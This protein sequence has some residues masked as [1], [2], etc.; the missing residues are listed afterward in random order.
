MAN[1]KDELPSAI[2]LSSG[3]TG[4]ATIRSLARGGMT[5]YAATSGSSQATDL[6]RHCRPLRRP[7]RLGDDASSTQWLIDFCGSLPV[8]PVVL[9]TSDNDALWLARHAQALRPHCIFS[10]S[11]H[12]ELL[13]IIS[14]DGL[15]AAGEQTGV[16]IVPSITEPSLEALDAWSLAH[17]APYLIKPFYNC[18]PGS[19]LK[20]KNLLVH[21]RDELCAY[22]AQHGSRAIIVQRKIDGGDGFILDCYGLCDAASQPVSMASHRRIRQCP[23]HFGSTSFGEIPARGDDALEAK[24]F[25]YTARLLRGLRYHGIFG[26]EWLQC[27]TSGELYV[28]DFNAR[29]FSSIGHL[30]DCGLN[31]PLLAYGELL[32]HEMKGTAPRPSLAHLYWA[33]FMGDA[34]GF[35]VANDA[36]WHGWLGSLLRCRSFAVWDWS[37]PGPW[38]LETARACRSSLQ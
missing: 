3:L 23:P 17:P 9:P 37:D 1:A 8:R 11:S 34:Y 19:A 18:I 16:P 13:R 21:S 20:Q 10:S 35:R 14:K 31:L 5:V 32:G 28:I 27:R 7:E 12:G 33:D 29:P 15:Y 6:S 26:I 36:T 30:T 2:V 24:L 4:L 25:D 22:V 38:L